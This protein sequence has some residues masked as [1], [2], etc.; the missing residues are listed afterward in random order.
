MNS[1]FRRIAIASGVLA[2]ALTGILA[3]YPYYHP[4]AWA[5]QGYEAEQTVDAPTAFE[6][7]SDETSYYVNSS[8]MFD[9]VSLQTASDIQM[10]SVEEQERLEAEAEAEAAAQAAAEA[11]AAA[12]YES[13]DYSDDSYDSYEYYDQDSW[14][15]DVSSYEGTQG[16]IDEGGLVYYWDDYYAA[17]NW[18]SEGAIIN[19]VG[20]GDTIYV[21][22][23]TIVVDGVGSWDGSGD[24][25]DIKDTY[26]WDKVYF[27]TC[28]GYGGDT[29]VYGHEE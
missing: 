9:D 22:G 8:H 25:G 12:Y 15:M 28:D 17:H 10:V 29:I 1:G 3:I 5:T 24:C 18:T 13:Y 11:E 16:A 2:V 6:V 19:S 14:S 20:A 7:V 26:G 21:D 23:R 4:V 27:Q